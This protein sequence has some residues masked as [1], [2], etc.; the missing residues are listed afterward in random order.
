MPTCTHIQDVGVSC[1]EAC[2][3]GEVRL[4]DGTDQ[5]NGR[6]EICIGGLWGTVCD[7]EFGNEDARV[8]CKQLGLEYAG[9]EAKVDAHFGEGDDD[10]ALTTLHCNGD[11][12]ALFDCFFKTG[13]AVTCSHANDAG[14]V[15]QGLCTN[16]DIRLVDGDVVQENVPPNSG[17]VEVCF[18]GE[19][20]TVC[21]NGWSTNDANVVCTQAGFQ[22]SRE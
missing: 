22:S 18:N 9:A 5:T 7:E 2:T 21:D 10:V 16:G 12:S 8:V 20:G 15:C 13:S 11:E 3:T 14:V 19:W 6:L 4:L 17:R 1:E